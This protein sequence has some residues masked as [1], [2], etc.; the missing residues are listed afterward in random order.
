MEYQ[1]FNYIDDEEKYLQKVRA[2]PR[3][4]T[5]ILDKVEEL[6][7][8]QIVSKFGPNEIDYVMFQQGDKIIINYKHLL[9]SDYDHQILVDL[10]T[11][12]GQRVDV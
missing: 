12:V 11:F 5:K 3:P 4:R 9:E 6:W 2:R 10:R 1:R 8:D 7:L